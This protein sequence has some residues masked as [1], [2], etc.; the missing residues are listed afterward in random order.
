MRSII[1]FITLFILNLSLLNA[2][3]LMRANACSGFHK[4]ACGERPEG[5]R[6]NGQSKSASFAPGD[7][8]ELDFLAY[9]GQDYRISVCQDETF[10]EELRF[11]L[12]EKQL[13]RDTVR[14]MNV[15]EYGG[16]RDTS[17]ER[18]VRRKREKVLLYDNQED[19]NAKALEF[20]NPDNS[21]RLIIQL[22]TYG[23]ASSSSDNLKAKDMGCVGVRIG[24]MPT[25]ESGF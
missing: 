15:T 7:T 18:R 3:G 1:L 20:S 16:T 17:Y 5:F 10:S 9:A 6:R 19:D 24:H 12:F 4:K 13:T 8:S 14:E 22:I 11:R 2:Q 23:D 25:Q 21:R